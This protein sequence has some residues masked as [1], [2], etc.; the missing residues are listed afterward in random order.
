MTFKEYLAKP[1]ARN[2]IQGDFVTDARPDAKLPDVTTWA[3]LKR[4]QLARRGILIKQTR[5]EHHGDDQRQL[6]HSVGQHLRRTRCG[7]ECL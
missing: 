6:H 3:E 5:V 1:Q 4:H 2:N 7:E